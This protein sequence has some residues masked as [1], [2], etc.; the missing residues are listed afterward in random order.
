MDL[1]KPAQMTG[2]SLLC[3]IVA[4]KAGATAMTATRD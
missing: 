2:V 1:P 4:A 3:P